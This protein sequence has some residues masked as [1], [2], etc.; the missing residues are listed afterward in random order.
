[1]G[2][3]NLTRKFGRSNP[4]RFVWLKTTVNAATAQTKKLQ[5]GF[6]DEVW[7]LVN[8]RALY[9]DKNWYTHPI[10][11]EPAGR[12]S[13]E[14]TSFSVPLQAGDNTILI[15]VANDFYGWGIIARLDDLVSF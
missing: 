12:C 7:V 1:M 4:R 2:L 3:V 13:I 11:K 10:R 8:G 5:L 9:T 15:G 6:S 14:N